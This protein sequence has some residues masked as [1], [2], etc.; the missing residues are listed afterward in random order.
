MRRTTAARTFEQLGH[1][2]QELDRQLAV[3]HAVI[4]PDRQVH[5]RRATIC[6]SRT[7]GRSTILWTPRIATSG[8]LITG[9]ELMAPY[10]PAF[11]MLNVPP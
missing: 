6:P 8:T 10:T 5:H 3:D 1:A 4:E 11:V 7:T 2:A 9:D